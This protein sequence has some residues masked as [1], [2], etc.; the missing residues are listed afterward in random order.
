[1]RGNTQIFSPLTGAEVLQRSWSS[2]EK[3]ELSRE[4]G[5]LQI[6]WSSAEKLGLCRTLQRVQ[7]VVECNISAAAPLRAAGW[8]DL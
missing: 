4:T 8:F 2:A 6:S 3:L 7:R 5:A 1:M